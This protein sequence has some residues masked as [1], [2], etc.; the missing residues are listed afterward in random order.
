MDALPQFGLWASCCM[1]WC[2][3]TSHLNTMRRSQKGRSSSGGESPQV[4]SQCNTCSSSLD[5]GVEYFILSLLLQ[6]YWLSS[7]SSSSRM[8]AA[9][10]VVSVSEA[11]RSSI[12]R[13]DHQPLVDAEHIL[14]CGPIH[15][16]DGEDDHR[17]QAAQHRPRAHGL[18]T[19]PCGRGSVM[20]A[21]SSLGGCFGPKWT[22][23]TKET[24]TQDLCNRLEAEEGGGSAQAD[25][26]DTGEIKV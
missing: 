12:L 5:T 23:L 24:I 18:H 16:A 8:P 11:S 22:A 7:F 13:G 10:Q 6:T 4:N 19:H 20:A 25:G 15:G 1:T 3:G 2:V 26:P 21:D 17:D 14:L 9:D